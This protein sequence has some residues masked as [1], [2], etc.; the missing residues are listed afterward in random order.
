MVGQIE[1]EHFNCAWHSSG[2]SVANAFCQ[3][4]KELEMVKFFLGQFSKV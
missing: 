3:G 4:D 1:R 2:L